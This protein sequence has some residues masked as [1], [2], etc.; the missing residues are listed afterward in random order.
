MRKRTESIPVN[1]FAD[2]GDTGISIERISISDLSALQESTKP[3]RH[4]RHSFFLLERGAVAMEIDLQEYRLEAPAIIYMHPDQVHR[5]IDFDH[6]IV[7]SWAMTN[8]HLN[9]KYLQLL[10][11]LLPAKPILLTGETFRMF[12]DTVSLVMK[13][14]AKT[15][16]KLYQAV[17][18]DSCNALVALVLAQ[19]SSSFLLPN[20]TSRFSTISK[21][22]RLLLET[23]YKNWKRPAEYAHELNISVAYLNECVKQATGDPVSIHIQ[24][25]IILE[26]KRLLYHTERSVKEIAIELGYEDY[27]YFSRLFSKTTGMPAITFRVKN[28]G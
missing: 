22:F 12:S 13:F 4:D 19:Y 9:P 7:T 14:F 23:N 8:E 17:L 27:P 28:H 16:N 10:E 21:A 6:V 3:E 2:E 1:H 5:M 26:A 11:D 24:Q 15:P 18:H 20:K 25:R